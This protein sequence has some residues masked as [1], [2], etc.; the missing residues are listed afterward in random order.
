MD[1]Y[2]RNLKE[3]KMQLGGDA[4]AAEAAAAVESKPNALQKLPDP[5]LFKNPRPP[6]VLG[7]ERDVYEA[8]C[9]GDYPDVTN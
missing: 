2:Q 5:H 3:V 8:L 7:H 9:R 4:A 6:H 1:Y